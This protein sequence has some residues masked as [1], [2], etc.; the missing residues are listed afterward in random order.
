MLD[1]KFIRE[2]EELVRQAIANKREDVDLDRLLVLDER[3]RALLADVEALKAQR[4]K[5]SETIAAMK[6]RG[7]D[8]SAL[9]QEMGQVAERIKQLDAQLDEVEK[10]IYEVQI[11]IPNVPHPSVPVGDESANVVI[12]HWGTVETFDFQPK[13]HWEIGEA[14][15]ILDLAG[16]AKVA[17]AFFVNFR[18][19]GAKLERALINFMLDL[20]VQ[21]HGYT[22]VFPPFVT[23]RE[24]MFGTGQ[25]PKLEKDM[26]RVEEDDLFLIPTAEVPVTNLH[27]DEIL[28]GDTLPLY[29]TA[30][31]PCFR[32][33][34]GSYGRDTRG[35]VR[36]HQFDKV[37]MVKFVKPE[38]SYDELESLLANAEE[39]LQLLN[40][41]YRVKVLATGD[42]SFAAAK[43][44]D[45]E[46]W[47]A[48]IGKW[49]EVSSCSNFEAFQARRANIR[50]RRSKGAKPE[51]VHT[52]NG[53][54]LA[55]PRTVIAILE[56]YQTDEGTVVVPEVL[57]PY[58]GVDVLR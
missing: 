12:K 32:R 3:R 47:A 2:N 5:V 37:E 49:L 15:G 40:L 29:Y 58:M 31:T 45:I 14:L 22:E 55:L 9:I 8:A 19:L 1:L 39:V 20:H 11:R 4:N 16:G 26:Y 28:D 34:A 17:G 50:F 21:K 57:R 25:I 35:L 42:L 7:E 52:L 10:A 6:K 56:N 44:Y 18:G 38:T 46:V 33:E 43:C 54:G 48:G 24:S 36:I 53:S 23:K 51:Y 30:Y 13:T 41:P 27:R